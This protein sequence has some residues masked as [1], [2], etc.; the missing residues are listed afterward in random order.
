MFYGLGFVLANAQG[1]T[2]TSLKGGA[3]FGWFS[4]PPFDALKLLFSIARDKSLSLK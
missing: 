2:K 4:A 3:R 1:M